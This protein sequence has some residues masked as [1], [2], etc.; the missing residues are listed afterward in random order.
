MKK[1]IAGNWKMNGLL[2]DANTLINNII[3]GY[4]DVSKTCDLLVCPPSLHI[5]YVK[6]LIG[7]ENIFIGAQDCSAHDFGAH[8]G[9]NAASMIA[10]IGCSYVILGHS[11]RRSDHNETDS[12]I[13]SK[14]KKA[15][16][17]GII[18][19]IC[20]GETETDRDLGREFDVVEAQL[21]GS[22]SDTVTIKN[23]VI[24]YEPVWAIGTGKTASIKDVGNMHKFIREY[25]E[26]NLAQ[27]DTM[28]I[29]YGGS[30]KPDNA[31]GLFAVE[32]VNGALIG[33]ASLKSD[34]FIAI[35][36]AT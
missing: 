10:D 15:H 31:A 36:R 34:D 30:V 27:G 4:D 5:G 33:G 7:N 25:L 19:I 2:A 17:A 18:T 26:Q 29:L 22:L 13:A 23:T 21:K 28:R 6:N 16:E 24:A 8:T 1:L 14:A 11:E 20:V 12:L 32:N 9:D 3:E 35:A